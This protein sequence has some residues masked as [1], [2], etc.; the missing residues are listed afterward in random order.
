MHSGTSNACPATAYTR[1][2]AC[3]DQANVNH[4]NTHLGTIKKLSQEAESPVHH[5]GLPKTSANLLLAKGTIITMAV[6]VQADSSHHSWAYISNS[7]LLRPITC[8]DSV[9]SIFVN[10]KFVNLSKR[11][12]FLVVLIKAFL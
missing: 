7:P 9:I 2:L 10:D 12:G 11:P 6:S 4:Y 1:T 5:Y 3:P 8:K